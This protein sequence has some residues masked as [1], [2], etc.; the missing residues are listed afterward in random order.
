MANLIAAA[1]LLL[2]ASLAVTLRKTYFYLPV[3]ELKRQ[4]GH[5]DP[6]ARKLYRA[7]AYGS[8]LR[9]FLWLVTGLSSAGAFV[10]LARIAPVWL[11][12]LGILALL[13]LEFI[14]LPAGRLSRVGTR[15]AIWLTRPIAWLMNYLHPTLGRVAEPVQRRHAKGAHTGLFEREDLIALLDKQAQQ[16]DS[17]LAGTEIEAAK[18]ALRFD[19]R[20]VGDIL[21]PRK[22]IKTVSADDTVGPV[23]IDELHK[24]DVPF[25]L[26][27]G[28]SKDEIFG[29][30]PIA[31]LGLHTSGK[32]RDHM[33][34]PVAYLHER[35]SL[36]QALQAFYATDHSQFVVVNDFEEFVGV[37]NIETVVNELLGDLGSADFDAYTDLSAVANRH[38][39][40]DED[41][42]EVADDDKPL[43]EDK[44]TD[45]D[46]VLDADPPAEEPVDEATDDPAEE[47]PHGHGDDPDFEV[48]E[49][50]DD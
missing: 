33:V 26:V 31:G 13:G 11:S 3:L 15:L 9:A 41:L 27:S 17:R 43:A 21:T 6:L 7:A 50:S 19:D 29:T 16:T 47:I 30:L 14:W 32:V 12:L 22:Q 34:S 46:K 36:R 28:K 49:V 38:Q 39:K 2:L 18:R 20:K 44:P 24:L 40:D 42:A 8:S 5:G 25:V 45:D 23:L 4:A 48:V 10:L 35:D 37:V 1:A